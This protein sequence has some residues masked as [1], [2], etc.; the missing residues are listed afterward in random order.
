VLPL[1]S[2]EYVIPFDQYKKIFSVAQYYSVEYVIPFATEGYK[3]SLIGLIND[4]FKL[5]G[6]SYKPTY[7][8]SNKILF[9][10]YLRQHGFQTPEYQYTLAA[11]LEDPNIDKLTYPFIIKPSM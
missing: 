9:H 11:R 2:K 4:Y 1:I 10:K 6:P 8:C 5:I 3:V 7:V